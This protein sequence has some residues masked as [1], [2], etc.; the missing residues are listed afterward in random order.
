MIRLTNNFFFFGIHT[1]YKPVHF[2]WEPNYIILLT[3]CNFPVTLHLHHLKMI[4]H[5]LQISNPLENFAM[6]QPTHTGTTHT[7]LP[8][9]RP[10]FS[11]YSSS[12]SYDSLD[13]GC[14]KRRWCT[15]KKR[16]SKRCSNDPI[17]NSPKLTSKLLKYMYNT[18]AT[19]FNLKEDPLH[20]QVYLLNLMN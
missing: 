20:C 7:K 12:D 8:Q 17:K 14:S 13:P 2:S 1:I 11:D 3:R 19:R 9:Y 5:I 6:E 16:W 10:H 4:H 15:R 18:K